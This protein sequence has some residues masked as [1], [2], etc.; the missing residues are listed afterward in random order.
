MKEL[1][2]RKLENSRITSG[3]ERQKQLATIE[4]SEF[5]RN[6]F[7]ERQ[8]ARRSELAKGVQEQNQQL[9]YIQQQL[10]EETTVEKAK[11]EARKRQLR[12]ELEGQMGEAEQNRLKWKRMSQE[13]TKLNQSYLALQAPLMVPGLY[14]DHNDIRRDRILD[15]FL[16]QSTPSPSLAASPS[17]PRLTPHPFP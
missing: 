11:R 7:Q 15:S 16:K 1:F 13:E 6:V 8:M 12:T 10:T 4:T 5:N 9:V 14:K 2:L 3:S 17:R